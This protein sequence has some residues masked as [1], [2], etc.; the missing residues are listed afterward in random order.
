MQGGIAQT[1]GQGELELPGHPRQRAVDDL[2]TGVRREIWLEQGGRYSQR[3]AESERA[4]AAEQELAALRG[5]APTGPVIGAPEE[6]AHMHVSTEADATAC[7]VRVLRVIAEG[8]SI[9]SYLMA[10]NRLIVTLDRL[11]DDHQRVN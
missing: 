7:L 1:Q 3:D 4:N 2:A 6:S 5:G 9:Q 8:G 10:G 11:Q